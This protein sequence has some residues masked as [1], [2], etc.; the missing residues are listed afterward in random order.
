MPYSLH[1][2]QRMEQGNSVRQALENVTTVRMLGALRERVLHVAAATAMVALAIAATPSHAITQGVYNATQKP[3]SSGA[4]C[5]NCHNPQGGTV[6]SVTIAGP[7]TLDAGATGTYTVTAT[8]AVTL[9]GVRMG[10]N[11]AASDGS[12]GNA[13]G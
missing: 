12:L 6:A 3:G 7:A 8:Q 5:A 1:G 11:V 10:I 9:A 2:Q 13:A 4:G